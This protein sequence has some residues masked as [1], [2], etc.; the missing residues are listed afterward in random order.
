MT[1]KRID[2]GSVSRQKKKSWR[3]LVKETFTKTRDE[4]YAESTKGERMVYWMSIALACAGIF[5]LL[6]LS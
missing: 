6:V 2:T 3:V 5:Y 4:R 1:D